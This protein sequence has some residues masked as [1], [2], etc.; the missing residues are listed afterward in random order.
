MRECT[1]SMASFSWAMSMLGLRQVMNAANP[2]GWCALGQNLEPLAR[3]AE[4]QLG[5]AEQALFKSGDQLQR[6]MVDL[7][8]GMMTMGN[9]DLGGLL[10][11]GMEA[12]QSAVRT[13]TDAMRQT[14]QGMQQMASSAA[15]GA[16]WGQSR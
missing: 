16:S 8:F 11:R 5:T 6:Q 9:G 3:A 14:T 12:A 13:G 15:A 1:K 7:A 4:Q 10:Q 2:G